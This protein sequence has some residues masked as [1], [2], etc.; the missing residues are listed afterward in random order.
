MQELTSQAILAQLAERVKK[1]RIDMNLSQAEFSQK[2]GVSLRSITNFE[3]GSD[4]KFSNFIKIL[5]ALELADNLE[6]LVPDVSKRPS[7]FLVTEKQKQGVRKSGKKQENNAFSW[8]D[9]KGFFC[10]IVINFKEK[11]LR[12]VYIS[13][14]FHVIILIC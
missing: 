13:G 11:A 4:V 8:G 5:K 6:V 2:A 3:S 1:Y 9:E 10:Y 12:T 7:T 14:Y